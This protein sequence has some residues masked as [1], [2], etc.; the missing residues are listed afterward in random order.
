MNCFLHLL[1]RVAA[2]VL[3]IG[4]LCANATAQNDNFEESFKRVSVEEQARLRAVL[5]A[6][7]PN[8][9]TT[10]ETERHFS[11]KEIAAGRLEDASAKLSVLRQ[12]VSNSTN[13]LPRANL[14]RYLKG[15]GEHVE[16]E[17]FTREAI[18]ATD[19]PALAAHQLL[20]LAGDQRSLGRRE[21]AEKTV[22]QAAEQIVI[23]TTK[24]RP[25]AVDKFRLL[26]AQAL[27][28]SE[29]SV[30]LENK[31]QYRQALEEA[32]RAE[33]LT[34]SN[35]Q[36]Y[37]NSASRS[38]DV[39]IRDLAHNFERKLNV[40]RSAGL[41]ADAEATLQSYIKLS[42][43]M[44]LPLSYLSSIYVA[45]ARLRLS[46]RE[47]TQSLLFAQRAEN[48][49]E[50]NGF[51]FDSRGRVLRR[52]EQMYARMGLKQWPQARELLDGYDA[53]AKKDSRLRN[54]IK[55]FDRA[56]V[57]LHTGQAAQ[58]ARLFET[59]AQGVAKNVG[60]TQF[61]VAQSSG[62]H[63]V[64]LWRS[65][66][67]EQAKA[68]AVLKK[69]VANYLL[70]S[71]ADF[72]ENIGL[73]GYYR[74]LIFST[75]LE[76]MATTPDEDATQA[77]G[78][79]DWV[80]SSS[81][82]DSLADAAVRAAASTPALAEVVRK[83]QDTKNEIAALRSY[84]SGES[85]NA[86]SPLPEVAQQMRERIAQLSVWRSRLQIDIKAQFPDYER[87]VRPTPPTVQSVAQKL[88]ASQA[89]LMLLP[90]QDAVYVW[91]V[92]ND[93]PAQ[94][95]RVPLG[96]AQLERMV[97]LLRT[98]LDLGGATTAPTQYDSAVA[99][100]LYNQLLAPVA[101]AWKGKTQ[102]IVA[103]GGILS[104]LPFAVLHTAPGG[105]S[106][107]KAPWLIQQTAI[108]QVP[109]LS[110]WIAIK[111]LA[112]AAPAKEAFI[113]WGDPAFTLQS[114][115][116]VSPPPVRSVSLSRSSTLA[117]LEAA[118]VTV[119]PSALQYRD[120][121]ALPDTRDELRA[122]ATALAADAQRDVIVGAQATRESVLTANRNGSL[123]RKRVVA[124]ATHGLMAGDLPNL[125]QP[126][127]ALAVTSATN[128]ADPLAPLLLLEDVLTLKLNA[129][130][131]V[132]SACNT[133][134]ADGKAEEALS[135]LARGFFYAGSRS[136]LVTHWS[137]DSESATLLT[138]ATFEHY[139]ANPQAPKA[140]S[141]RQAMLKVMKMPK[142]SHPAF[143]A[144][145]ALV[146]DGGR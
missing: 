128:P 145:Y 122:I 82:Q 7:I 140:E 52:G 96:Q 13:F 63:G 47:F 87:L 33:Q 35:L 125:N 117:D 143:W 46:Q 72:L 136:L 48:V 31:L 92:A 138:S 45:A 90:T 109:S 127:L 130:W 43:E 113:G 93:Q 91:A 8:S 5:A 115:A 116:S 106:D 49:L 134:A 118:I 70:P 132:L 100:S 105:G 44:E 30:E 60:E 107:A 15:V 11:E 54:L 62:L 95:V 39:L 29:R 40:Q 120:I 1:R 32:S 34:R 23:A 38:R 104:Q 4:L 74:E 51:E 36:N 131:V 99:F 12:W 57:Y 84:L 114:S 69:S 25:S 76:A 6:P 94:F 121:P 137:V 67:V 144:P 20:L 64:A 111:S 26:R 126:A 2:L 135:G 89:L 16:S 61:F 133:A 14:G 37:Q 59:T 146:G 141:L 71:N 18:A 101:K 42:K 103:A 139:A 102:V 85:G 98:Q 81:V 22:A 86:V 3:C 78:P 24:Q 129:D 97:K 65:G 9:M 50:Q 108:T 110:A 53:S 73:R 88:D 75:Y 68:L 112:K 41:L 124:F 123:T 80:R 83:E 19:Q 21:E 28:S 79:A 17:K 10:V 142:F 56:V 27:Y 55:N 77:M 66:G 119:S 58:A